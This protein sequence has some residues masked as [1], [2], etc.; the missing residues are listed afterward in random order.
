M[1]TS[2]RN[3][4]CYFS[5]FAVSLSHLMILIFFLISSVCLILSGVTGFIIS[6]DAFIEISFCFKSLHFALRLLCSALWSDL[7]TFLFISASSHKSKGSV[8]LNWFFSILLIPIVLELISVEKSSTEAQDIIV[9]G[10]IVPVPNISKFTARRLWSSHLVTL[11]T[12]L[13]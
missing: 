4:I 8:G 1:Q 7:R 5:A 10:A 11:V 6:I 9:L 3:Y 12:L 2:F 13:L